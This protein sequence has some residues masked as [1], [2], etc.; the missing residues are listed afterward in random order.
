MFTDKMF[1]TL[2]LINYL[3][4]KFYTKYKQVIY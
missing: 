1:Y 4:I 2:W 3:Q